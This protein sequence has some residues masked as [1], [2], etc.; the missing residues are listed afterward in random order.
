MVA[1]TDESIRRLRHS[2]TPQRFRDPQLARHFL[3]VGP[4]SKTFFVQVDIA[5]VRPSRILTCDF[6]YPNR[7]VNAALSLSRSRRAN[8]LT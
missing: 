4:H 5:T 6:N 2:P 1:F 3:V 8:S 7:L